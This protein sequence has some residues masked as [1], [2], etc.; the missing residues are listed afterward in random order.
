MPGYQT[1]QASVAIRGAPDLLIRSL[2]DAQQYDDPLGEAGALGI[3]SATWPLF[4]VLW[5]SSLQLAACMAVRPLVPGERLLEVGCG[6]ALG[7]LVAHR[8]GAAVTASD[9]HPL[10]SLFLARNARLNGLAPLPYRHGD[11]SAVP[12]QADSP[13]RQSVEGRFGLI[14]GSDVLYERD[15]AGQLQ[16]F[17]ERHALPEAEVLIV[18]PNRSNRAAFNRRMAHAGFGLEELALAEVSPGDAAYRGRL[19]RYRRQG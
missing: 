8:R 2:L 5:P 16:A 10:A 3:S 13:P 17:I 9:C 19:L 4:G 7:S 6:L 14:M 12:G 18:D 15:E 1:H 11:W